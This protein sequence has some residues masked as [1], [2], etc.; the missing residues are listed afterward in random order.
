MDRTKFGT[1]S[2]AANHL[3]ISRQRIHQLIQQDRLGKCVRMD[4][5]RGLV[6]FIPKPFK[7]G[8]RPV[9]RPKKGSEI[10]A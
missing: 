7:V 6:I 8:A 4:T 5:P 3:G 2:E 10:I 9:G 1:V